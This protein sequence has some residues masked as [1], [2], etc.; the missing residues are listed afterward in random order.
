MGKN[1]AGIGQEELSEETGVSVETEGCLGASLG[2]QL[3]QNSPD[4]AK[5]PAEVSTWERAWCIQ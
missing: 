2:G 3:G 1:K 4:R 5:A